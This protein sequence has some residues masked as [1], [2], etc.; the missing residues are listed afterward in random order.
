MNRRIVLEIFKKGGDRYPRSTKKPCTTNLSGVSFNSRT[1]SPIN[2]GQMVHLEVLCRLTFEVR[3]GQRQDVRPRK[4]YTVPVAGAWWSAVVPR[5]ERSVSPHRLL[6]S[7]DGLPVCVLAD[8]LA[9]LK[10]VVIASADW[11][12]PVSTER[13]R[14]EEL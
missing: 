1:G 2:H 3:R 7:L 10:L 5:L 8:D 12:S 11:I 14:L 6:L 4:I 9:V 13:L